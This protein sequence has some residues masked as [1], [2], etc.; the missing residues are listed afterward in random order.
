MFEKYKQSILFHN[1]DYHCTFFY[2][3]ALQ[4]LGWRVD[5]F[6]PNYYPRN[7]LYSAEKILRVKK[8]TGNYSIDYVIWFLRTTLRYKYIVYYG[9]PVDL[10]WLTKRYFPILNFEPLLLF[11]KILKKKIIY[12]P[13]GCRDEFTQLDFSLFDKGNVCGN[14]G[15]Y[16]KCDEKSNIRNLYLINKYFDLVIGLGF[17]APKIRK[18]KA[19]KWKS[20]NLCEYNPKLVV[21]KQFVLPKSKNLRILHSTNLEGRTDNGKDIKG[22][23]YVEEA[24]SR[25]VKEGYSC[26]LLRLTDI[27]SKYMR[28]Y[29]VQADLVVDQLIYGHFGS[30]SL[31]GLALGKPV[32][33]YFNSVWKQNYIKTHGINVWPFIEANTKNIYGVLKNL[34]DNP[35]L[36]K[37]YSKLSL[38]FTGNYLDIETNVKEFI[39]TLES[40]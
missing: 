21:P 1:P 33:C 18:L 11:L 23:K 2:Q 22:S 35:Q 9:R 26:E 40:I 14:C 4:K 8:F 20:F 29:Q 16:D 30:T 37:V 24:V 6:V 27:E 38:E 3:E 34:M 36:I 7:L 13:S 17:T 15:F 32:I 12:I 28:F 31:E 39:T 10:L 25:L 5:I 19:M